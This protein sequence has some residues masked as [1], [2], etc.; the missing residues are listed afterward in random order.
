MVATA[1]QKHRA[2]PCGE[3][4]CAVLGGVITA[5]QGLVG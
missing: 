1:I 5:V 2:K 4:A 3:R